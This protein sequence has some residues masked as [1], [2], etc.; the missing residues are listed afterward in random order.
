M[1]RCIHAAYESAKMARKIGKSHVS[2]LF[3]NIWDCLESRCMNVSTEVANY[4][5]F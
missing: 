4:H 3:N 2:A 1:Q 5:A